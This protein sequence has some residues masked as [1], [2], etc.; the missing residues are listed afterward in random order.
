MK[1]KIG[2]LLVNLGTPDSTKT[3][4]V[5]K[6]LREFLM[7]GRVIDINP[8]ARFLLVNGIIAP[9][10]AP[11]SAA[12]YRKL[13]TEKGSPLLF[14]SVELAALLQQALGD[15]F[16]VRLGMRY[17]S[18]SLEA[19][20]NH[21]KTNTDHII[22][23]PLFP[24][25]A[26]ATTGSVH[27]AVMQIVSKWQLIPKLTLIDTYA[28]HPKIIKTFAERGKKYMA[29]KQYDHFMFSFHGLPQRQLRKADSEC[30][31]DGCCS[32]YDE[33]NRL[34]YRAQ[35]FETSRLLAAELGLTAEQY[36]VTFQS[37]LGRDPW[38]TPY[39]DETIEN[40]GKKGVK[41][42][43]VFSPAFVADCLETIVEIG[44]AYKE[45]FHEKYGGHLQLVESLNT[46]PLWV[47]ALKEIVISAK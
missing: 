9:F 23:V 17:Q 30:I 29:E 37:R 15:D 40:L 5:R 31:K 35:C 32:V 42:L 22:V 33:R 4:D 34:C 18:P 2:V 16:E 39:T 27:Q 41:N 24:Q 10:R 20:I 25:Y 3:S 45:L 47:E 38:I 1:H 26:S 44:E 12:E 21:F 14:H 19:A 36:S 6:Y 8:I 28:D 7:D 13:W 43:L 46:H 11:K